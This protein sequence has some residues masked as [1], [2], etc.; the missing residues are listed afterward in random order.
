MKVLVCLPSL[1]EAGTIGT[2]TRIVDKGLR[3]V[4]GLTSARI[5]NVDSNSVDGTREVFNKEITY[6]PKTSIV[7]QGEPGKG[8]N[9]LSFTEVARKEDADFCV[10]IDTDITS[11]TE[12]WMRRLLDPLMSG[13]AD[14]VTPLYERSRFEGSSTNHFAYPVIYGFTGQR[15]RQP[16]AGDFAFNRLFLDVLVGTVPVEAVYGYGIDIFLSLVAAT[17]PLRIRQVKLGKKIHNPSFAKLEAMFPQIAASALAVVR[18]ATLTDFTDQSYVGAA[19]ILEVKV[20][21]HREA[22]RK[23]LGRARHILSATTSSSYVWLPEPIRL[24]VLK[25]AIEEQVN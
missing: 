12:D 19:N 8:R 7:P 5:V 3:S 9:L 6:Y 13:E 2:V 16:I 23:M 17:V 20:F 21:P 15:V 25:L 18:Q 22:A 1:N 14:Y 11:V 4:P 10:T 24:T